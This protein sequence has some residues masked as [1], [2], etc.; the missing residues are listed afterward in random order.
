MYKIGDRVE[1]K[2]KQKVYTGVVMP[3]P[4]LADKNILILKLDS[5]YN[6]GI[7]I[8]K[9]TKIKKIGETKLEGFPKYKPP[10]NPKLP[11]VSM[12]TTGGTITSRVDYKTGAVFPLESAEELLLSVPELLD[13]VNIRQ[14][15][16]P[17]ALLSEDMSSTEWQKLA[18]LAA[19]LLN[20]DDVGLIITHGTDIL[21]YTAAALSFMLK[22]LSKPVAL[23]GGQRSSDRG[24]FDGALNLICAAHYCKSNIAEVAIV[25]HGEEAD[26]FCLANRGTKVRKLHTSR[27]DT[28]RPINDIPFAKIFKD[29]KMQILNKNYKQRFDHHA[30]TIADTAF[31]PKV[32]LVK[33]YPGAS[34]EILN[35]YIDKK[36]KGIIIEATG[37]GHVAT[38]PLE[39]KN[40]WLPAIKRAIEQGIFVGFAPQTI[41]GRLDPHVYRNARLMLQAGVIYLED[42]LPETAYIKLGCMIP[43]A[44]NIKELKKLMLTNF[45]GEINPKIQPNSFLY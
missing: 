1:V 41:Y 28:F 6:I 45:A 34:P 12:I 37:L 27:R 29:G 7:K 11:N 25:M 38:Q 14:I 15:Q 23:V 5:G 17:F 10:I 24:S 26:T 39:K 4:E 13:V 3:T 2:V 19:K 18:Q 21:H 40:S 31:E 8:T 32:A 9:D 33:F 44:K 22:N 30:E 16:Q 43:K 20:S 42:M 35:H 36:Y